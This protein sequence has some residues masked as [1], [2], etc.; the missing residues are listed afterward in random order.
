[1]P[2]ASVSF[3]ACSFYVDM[4]YHKS[5]R[6][7]QSILEGRKKG[8][9]SRKWNMLVEEEGMEFGVSTEYALFRSK[10]IICVN[11]IVIMLK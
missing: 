11:R 10:W 8:R 3:V 5:I 1:M 4:V 7:S 6:L 9:L 2:L